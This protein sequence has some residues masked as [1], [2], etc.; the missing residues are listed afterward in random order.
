VVSGADGGSRTA[1]CAVARDAGLDA[2]RE[3][4]RR[5]SLRQS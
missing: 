3:V 2:D 4:R 5:V 1:D